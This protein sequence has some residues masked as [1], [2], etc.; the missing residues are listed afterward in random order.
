[1][2]CKHLRFP[3]YVRLLKKKKGLGSSIVKALCVICHRT[4]VNIL[5]RIATPKAREG[6]LKVP[7]LTT[8]RYGVIIHSSHAKKDLP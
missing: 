6:L 5:V 8:S 3:I 7:H 4:I 2:L 1:M